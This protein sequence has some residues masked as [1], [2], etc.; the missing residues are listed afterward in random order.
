M[1][2]HFNSIGFQIENEE[3][4]ARLIEQI[5]QNGDEYE[6]SC[7]TFITWL[8]DG[9]IELTLPIDEEGRVINCNPHFVGQSR[10]MAGL[11]NIFQDEED[12]YDRKFLAWSNPSDPRDVESGEYPFVFDLP[13]Y[14]P[15]F[16]YEDQLPLAVSVQLAAFAYHLNCYRNEDEFDAAQ[17]PEIRFASESFVPI[18]LFSDGGEFAGDLTEAI[19][20]GRVLQAEKRENP[21]TGLQYWYIHVQTLG[22][23]IDIVADPQVVEG[24]PVAGGFVQGNFWLSGKIID[25]TGMENLE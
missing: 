14:G 13:E 12:H 18:G 22:G 8:V 10:M 7:S 16:Y 5:L 23:T 9:G 15:L 11:V 20:C 24:E 19:C 6:S 25:E 4:V 2:N 1:A 21:V 3:D 17:D